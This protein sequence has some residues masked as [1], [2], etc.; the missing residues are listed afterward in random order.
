ML[1]TRQGFTKGLNSAREV[2]VTAAVLEALLVLLAASPAA[3]A[4]GLGET[5]M[6]KEVRTKLDDTL[7]WRT[8]I[9][10]R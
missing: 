9:I 2:A 6:W 8:V 7:G 1:H 4:D 3:D 5:L 10:A